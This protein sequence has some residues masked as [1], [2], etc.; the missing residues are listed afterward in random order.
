M[1]AYL[2]DFSGLL[3]LLEFL[4]YLQIVV[5][6]HISDYHL[7]LLFIKLVHRIRIHCEPYIQYFGRL[8]ASQNNIVHFNMKKSISVDGI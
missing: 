1:H 2:D 8:E 3:V 7:V 6:Y 4:D 5:S